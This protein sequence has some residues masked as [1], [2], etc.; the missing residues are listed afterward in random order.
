MSIRIIRELTGT[1]SSE[2]ELSGELTIEEAIAGTLADEEGIVGE[3]TIPTMTGG[4]AYTGDYVVTPDSNTQI[5][6]TDGFIMTDNVTINPIPSNYG[7]I[8]WNGSVLTVS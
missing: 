7:L 3:I 6:A 4:T 5:L 8:T 2:S 1:L